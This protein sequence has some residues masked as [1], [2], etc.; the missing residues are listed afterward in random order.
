M[1]LRS[2]PTTLLGNPWPW[3]L[4]RLLLGA[5][6]LAA[7][8]LGLWRVK[9]AAEATAAQVRPHHQGFFTGQADTLAFVVRCWMDKPCSEEWNRT[10]SALA[11]PA[12]PAF[13]SVPLALAGVL[14]LWLLEGHRPRKLAGTSRWAGAADLRQFLNPALPGYYGLFRLGVRTW[15]M[16][17]L[18]VRLRNANTL[19]VGA[20]GTG[21][22]LGYFL[23]N[24][25][26]DAIQGHSAIVYDYKYPAQDGGL[27]LAPGFFKLFRHPVLAFR[28]FDMD[29]MRIDLLRGGEHFLRAS[30]IAGMVIPRDKVVT[31][32]SIYRDLARTLLKGLIMAAVRE[33]HASLG[34][35]ARLTGAGPVDTRLFVEARPW[36]KTVVGS[37][38]GGEAKMWSGAVN[39]VAE[40]LELFL[41]PALD[42]ATSLGGPEEMI[43]PASVFQR[44][45]LLYLG[46]PQE[47][48][49]RGDGRILLN[50]I[51][52]V[53]DAARQEA[54]EANGGSEVPVPTS[55]YLDEWP[56]FGELDGIMQDLA[57]CRSQN[58]AHHI[59]LQNLSQGYEVYGQFLFDAIKD[60]NFSSV[61]LFGTGMKFEEAERWSRLLGE[62][63]FVESSRTGKRDAPLDLI[64]SSAHTQKEAKR[65]LLDPNELRRMKRGEAILVV[66]DLPP[67]RV[68]LPWVFQRENPLSNAYHAALKLGFRFRR[69]PATPEDEARMLEPVSLG[70]R[71]SG[72]PAAGE[73]GEEALPSLVTWLEEALKTSC[74]VRSYRRGGL[75]TRVDLF[76][77]VDLDQR[78]V[79]ERLG[80]A[81]A[82]TGGVGL[83]L[84]ALAL[85]PPPLLKRL[86][87]SA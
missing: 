38:V 25:L 46:I 7:L 42:R 27:A 81:V 8:L 22:T 77:P 49:K 4:G 44:P 13:A 67:V 73:S 10:F 61:A 80:W 14:L 39:T 83:K 36:L 5:L 32:G 11:T 66:D 69:K 54:R 79:W 33:G 15:R 30:A 40:D 65:R 28:P 17:A 70:E 57:T 37:V 75:L 9:G 1:S 51:K 6:A 52:R 63:T 23:P 24:I 87:E 3:V 56:N 48:I 85:L 58:I 76:A 31:D 29:S 47:E 86:E 82:V 68:R 84:R 20:P 34:Y 60:T 62:A 21:K 16:L 50:L 35:L 78:V 53:V 72:A 26:K 64:A 55:V 18:P 59:G 41:H 74:T 19:V 45:S 71:P 43:E 2:E 12:L